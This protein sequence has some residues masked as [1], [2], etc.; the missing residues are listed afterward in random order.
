LEREHCKDSTFTVKVFN[1]QRSYADIN[2]KVLQNLGFLTIS[3]TPN[4]AVVDVDGSLVG[5][6]NATFS[7]TDGEHN[8]R[9][10]YF[11]YADTT[12][13]V[14][15]PFW[16]TIK[17]HIQ[18]PLSLGSL[19]IQSTP[20]KARVYVDGFFRGYT[21]TL[22]TNLPIGEHS[23]ELTRDFY[24]DTSFTINITQNEVLQRNITLVYDVSLI[25]FG[26]VRIYEPMPATINSCAL[27]LSD[28]RVVGLNDVMDLFYYSNT[29]FTIHEIRSADRHP[30]RFRH[31]DFLQ[32]TQVDL[33]DT[34]DAPLHTNNW[35]DH[36]SD[37]EYNYFFIYDEDQH[38]S[39]MIITN[40]GGGTSATDPAWIEVIWIYNKTV[41]DWRF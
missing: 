9:V 41:N 10:R 2:L 15:V 21:D 38:Y 12:F 34:I 37:R 28:A 18:F 14:V 39:K 24:F 40:Y 26:P 23:V 1:N 11:N 7:V 25:Q 13:S 19:N 6:T 31:T 4:E 35:T 30:N 36:L 20:N 27:D 5:K 33:N 29:D 8:I 3:S 17:T 22:L 32:T 16:D